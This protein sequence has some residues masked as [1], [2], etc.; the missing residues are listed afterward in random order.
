MAPPWEHKKRKQKQQSKI[1]QYLAPAGDTDTDNETD[2]DND[3]VHEPHTE[4]PIKQQPPPLSAST[5]EGSQ[6]GDKID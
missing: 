4:N 2:S 1:R 6:G 5:N 3:I